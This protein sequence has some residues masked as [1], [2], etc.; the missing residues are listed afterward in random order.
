[1]NWRYYVKCLAKRLEQRAEQRLRED[2]ELGRLHDAV[3]K[4]EDRLMAR[5]QVIAVLKM[6]L[7]AIR[8]G[9]GFGPD[10]AEEAL[11]AVAEMERELAE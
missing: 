2:D 3:V 1:M 5:D 9:K 10:L 11:D 8:D 6:A 4:L 7:I